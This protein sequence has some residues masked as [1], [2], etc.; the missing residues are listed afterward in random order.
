M[1]GY[2]NPVGTAVTCVY[3]DKLRRSYYC[4][5]C[6]FEISDRASEDVPELED[7]S[8][9]DDHVIGVL[10]GIK[11]HGQNDNPESIKG[12]RREDREV[13]ESTEQTVHMRRDLIA[14]NIPFKRYHLTGDELETFKAE[15]EAERHVD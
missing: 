3:A 10:F 8:A 5:N 7:A 13:S 15:A 1:C 9:S 2:R 11:K 4:M 14:D 6:W 12:A